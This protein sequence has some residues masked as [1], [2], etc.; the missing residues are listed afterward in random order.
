MIDGRT[1]QVG[2]TM[3]YVKVARETD[4]PLANTIERVRVTGF[5][6]EDILLAEQG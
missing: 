3:Q 6:T 4:L 5:L 2:H 1:F